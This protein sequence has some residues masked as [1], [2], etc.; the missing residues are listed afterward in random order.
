MARN[1][2]ILC[3]LVWGYAR[4]AE[5][6]IVSIRVDR[7][8]R[9]PISRGN[10]WLAGE[11]C[12]VRRL[13]RRLAWIVVARVSHSRLSVGLRWRR[14]TML[15]G[16]IRSLLTISAVTTIEVLTSLSGKGGR[17]V[18]TLNHSWW[19]RIVRARRHGGI[20]DQN[21][22]LALE[23]IGI[24]VVGIIVA[25]TAQTPHD[26]ETEDSNTHKRTSDTTD[27]STCAYRASRSRSS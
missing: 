17:S 16:R 11:I 19:A 25:L 27:D 7:S 20:V 8:E 10:G 12:P 5:I 1:I 4:A 14:A 26:E 3:R 24:K 2:G 18:V 21:C 13:S 22:R 9:R 15:V 6:D 23:C